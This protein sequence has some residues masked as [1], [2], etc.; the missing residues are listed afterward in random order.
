MSIMTIDNIECVRCSNLK[1]PSEYYA[2][3]GR[4]H[5]ECKECA[6]EL[7]RENRRARIEGRTPKPVQPQPTGI[8]KRCSNCGED[9]DTSLFHRDARKPDGL[10]GHCRSCRAELWEAYSAQQRSKK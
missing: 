2:R 3:L 5:K 8:Y 7:A 1:P 4:L 6:K 10:N 9:K